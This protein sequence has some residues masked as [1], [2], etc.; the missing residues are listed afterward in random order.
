LFASWARFVFRRRK[1][2]LAASALFIVVAA[3]ALV[4]GG[5]LTSGL[6]EGIESQRALALV[7][8]ATGRPAG[9]QFTVVFSS[10]SLTYAD[11]RFA[12][13][14]KRALAP[15]AA[16][17]RVLSIETPA[18]LPEQLARDRVSASGH[19][20]VA[21]VSLRDDFRVAQHQYPSIRALV[22]SSVLDLTFTGYLPFKQD[23]DRTLQADLVRAEAVSVPLALLVLLAVFATAVAAMLP[24]GVGLLAVVGGVAAV[25]LLSH[26]TDMAQYTINVVTLIGLGVAIDY[27]LFIVTRYRDELARGAGLEEALVVAVATAGRAVAFSGLAVGI[28]LA[29][30]LFFPHSYLY[31]MG[32]AGA[33][34]VG[35]AVIAALSFLPALLAT[36]G[37]GISGGKLPFALPAGTGVWRAIAHAVMQRPVLVLVPT[38]AFVLVLGAPFTRLRMAAADMRVLPTHVEAR[39]GHELLRAELPSEA[40]NRIVVAVRFP[41]APA[42]SAERVGALYDLSRRIAALPTVRK[43]ESLVDL[44]PSIGRGGYQTLYRVPRALLPSGIRFA[45]RETAGETT[46]I[47]AAISDAPPASDEARAVVRA[48]RGDR[49]VGDGTLVVTGATANDI[50]T[51]DFILEHTPAAVGFVVTATVIILFLLLGSV[52]LPLKAVVM[53]LLSIAASFGALVWVFQDGHLSGLLGFEPG[54]IE[55]TLPV[56]LF[57]ALF[58]LSMDYEVLLLTR[59]QEEYDRTGDNT[60]AV[61]D[62]LER[63]GRLITSAAAIMVAVFAAFALADIVLVKAMGFGMALAVALDATLV[64]ILIVPA[65]MRLFGDLNWW[66]P[67]WLRR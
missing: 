35:L 47:L 59:I 65:T 66:A 21:H 42:L 37:P 31:A 3:L 44:D 58:G 46:V 2:V 5:P 51:T 29:G 33:I 30:L 12:A 24:V 38:L 41:D 6:I 52:L 4:R 63:S 64:R 8:E 16:D 67:R 17:P 28:G 62:G 13:E 43:V 18:D 57:C 25:M 55:P 60:H 19:V 32:L 15:A 9:S 34:V 10:P 36:L 45:L 1:G 50:D 14:M 40:A 53:N 27:S 49:R 48:I 22:T 54:P 23:L 39:R 7:H 61:A 26:F 56:L 20:A 11:P